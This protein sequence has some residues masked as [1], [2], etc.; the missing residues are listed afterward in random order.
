MIMIIRWRRQ[1]QK[2]ISERVPGVSLSGVTI[3][4][5]PPLHFRAQVPWRMVPATFA[6]IK[7]L[8]TG[9]TE[10]AATV[11]GLLH[12][13]DD[14][15]CNLEKAL[16]RID[17]VENGGTTVVQHDSDLLDQIEGILRWGAGLARHCPMEST[18]RDL[19]AINKLNDVQL[20]AV[21][22]RELR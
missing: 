1:Q 20:R 7:I 6:G 16:G 9:A 18:A 8:A 19:A 13:S 11:V 21:M 2:R 17:I 4:M 22:L 14:Q 10:H 3:V 15:V 5:P 12:L